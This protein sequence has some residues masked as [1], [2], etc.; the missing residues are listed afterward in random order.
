MEMAI[1]Q[2]FSPEWFT[3][4]TVSPRNR[5]RATGDAVP[6]PLAKAI[7]AE[8]NS[9]WQWTNCTAIEICAGAGGLASGTASINGMKHLA[10]ID[11][12][13]PACEI[14]R[15]QKP[16][17][18]ERVVHASVRD[19]DFTPFKRRVGLL[20][21]GPP[22]QPWSFGGQRA[23]ASDPRDLLSQIHEIVALLEPEVFLFEN[24]PGL[25]CEQ[26]LAYLRAVLDRL[27]RPS[28][29]SPSYGVMAGILNAADFGV[30]QIRRR[31][32]IV[33]FR[34]APSSLSYHLL[35]RIAVKA[36]HRNPSEP[37]PTRARWVTVGEALRSVDDPG[38]W[39]K[40]V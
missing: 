22:C 26:H 9:V 23:G 4:P 40:W 3:V 27:R 18:A 19:Y 33:G 8:I 38:G 34:E 36:T 25:S 7:F 30:P 10:L 1:I 31:I 16:W 29:T 17:P 35:D 20:S 2:G 32:F 15:H 14:L 37:H 28:H 21:G 6:P 24:V 13:E 11:S 5:V 39:R 12:W